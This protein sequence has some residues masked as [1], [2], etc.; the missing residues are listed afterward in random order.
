MED[1]AATYDQNQDRESK[2]KA[3]LQSIV[4]DELAEP[5]QQKHYDV[6]TFCITSICC[7]H[8]S[9][10]ERSLRTKKEQQKDL[11]HLRHRQKHHW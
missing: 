3:K 5:G 4:E 6:I 11:M 8:N 10:L 2:I 7:P 1:R 9:Q